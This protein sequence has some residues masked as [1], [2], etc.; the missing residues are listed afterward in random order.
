MKKPIEELIKQSLENHELP[1][2]AAAWTSMNARL[3]QV[4]PTSSTGGA[5]WKFFGAAVGV[6]AIAVASYFMFFG[7]DEIQV[8][9]NL[10]AE[11]ELVE[12]NTNVDTDKSNETNSVANST[13]QTESVTATVNEQVT[14]PSNNE[15][16]NTVTTS[17]TNTNPASTI[18][19]DDELITIIWEQVASENNDNIDGKP[20]EFHAQKPGIVDPNLTPAEDMVLPAVKNLCVGEELTLSN[21]NNRY[22]VVLNSVGE[23]FRIPSGTTETFHADQ[24]GEY[25]LGFFVDCKF[26]EKDHFAVNG[27]PSADFDIDLDTKYENG[28]PTVKVSANGTSDSF[29]W[30]S[31]EQ[32]FRGRSADFHFFKEGNHTI[33]LTAT[34][35]SCSVS[36]EESVYVEDY[37]LMAVT[38]FNPNDSDPRNNTFIPFALTQ[39]N[40]KFRMIILDAR[41]G[42]VVYETNDA[43]KP[44]DG[45]DARIGK[46]NSSI[47]TYIWKVVLENPAPGERAEYKGS[48]TKL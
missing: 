31:G 30:T 16:N 29:V 5:S 8:N 36:K 17:T 6:T 21:P 25:R 45:T 27:K 2:N 3:D 34:N 46:V 20:I 12:N 18:P 43:N 11:N 37:N 26:Y 28:I 7:D 44:W 39:R 33:Q 22:L 10:K 23:R 48:I 14:V 13:Q 42:D 47:T 19:A 15:V 24:V 38:G 32:S 1:Y 41:T 35:G 4:K 40:V 9:P